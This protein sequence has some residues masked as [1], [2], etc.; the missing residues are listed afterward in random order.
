MGMERVCCYSG[1]GWGRSGREYGRSVRA[2]AVSPVSFLFLTI[3]LARQVA[4]D[5]PGGS[6]LTF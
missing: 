6:H 5:K 4:N 1:L 2:E 3:L